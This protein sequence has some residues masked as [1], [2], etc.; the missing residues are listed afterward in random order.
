MLV[1]CHKG[2]KRSPTILL[3]WMGTRGIRLMDAIETLD[4]QYRGKEGWAAVY[5]KTR[6][7][8][9]EELKV[10]GIAQCPLADPPHVA[11]VV[12]SQLG[13]APEGVERACAR[14]QTPRKQ[15]RVRVAPWDPLTPWEHHVGAHRGGCPQPHPAPHAG[16]AGAGAGSV[17]ARDVHR[18][19]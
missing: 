19:H 4:E 18:R 15:R 10:G 12:E 8:W 14:H 7:D 16:L 2:E 9:I 17:A 11:A 3:A 5:K 1:H 13:R 6:K